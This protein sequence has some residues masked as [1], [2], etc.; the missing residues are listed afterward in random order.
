MHNEKL[1]CC[2]VFKRDSGGVGGFKTQ[3]S[4]RAGKNGGSQLESFKA[5][6][7]V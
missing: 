5:G 2:T 7:K 6:R 4:E 3:W 1:R